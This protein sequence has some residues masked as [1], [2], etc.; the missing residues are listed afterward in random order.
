MPANDELVR[1]AVIRALARSGEARRIRERAGLSRQDISPEVG[2]DQSSIGRW[3]AGLTTPRRDA[4]LRWERVLRRL[5]SL[6]PVEPLRFGRAF[7]WST[8]E[9]L[10]TLGVDLGVYDPAP[11][12]PT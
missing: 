5:Q 8:A 6:E 2:A 3:E 1:L 4:A 10:R 9:V 11:T 12:Q 7:R